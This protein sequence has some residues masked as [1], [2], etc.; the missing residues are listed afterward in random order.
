VRSLLADPTGLARMGR[1]ARRLARPDAAAR[2]A[3]L[4]FEIEREAA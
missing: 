1:Q 2:L 3:E 4:L